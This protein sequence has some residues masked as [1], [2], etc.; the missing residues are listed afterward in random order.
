MYGS[1]EVNSSL[2]HQVAVA[3]VIHSLAW[4]FDSKNM[5]GLPYAK[6]QNV[7]LGMNEINIDSRT[8]L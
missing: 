5:V 2:S 8:A 6:E 7:S 4:I 3:D 1:S